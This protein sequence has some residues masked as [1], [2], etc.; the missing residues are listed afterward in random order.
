MECVNCRQDL[1]PIYKTEW[2]R[3]LACDERF[4]P[5]CWHRHMT[6]PCEIKEARMFVRGDSS[7]VDKTTGQHFES[8]RR[9]KDL[10]KQYVDKLNAKNDS[11]NEGLRGK[12]GPGRP[13]DLHIARGPYD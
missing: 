7:G 10:Q 11:W 12:D 1:G 6:E 8:R 3:C 5:A 13:V 2:R 9:H 4:C